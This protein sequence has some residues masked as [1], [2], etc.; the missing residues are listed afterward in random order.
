MFQ[1]GPSSLPPL[2]AVVELL[3][4]VGDAEL[5]SAAKAGRAR[6][7]STPTPNAL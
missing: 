5:E 4:E 3:E 7:R 1:D 6:Q 2:A